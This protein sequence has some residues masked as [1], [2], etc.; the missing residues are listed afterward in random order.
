MPK[1]F[2]F[3]TR[4]DRFIKLLGDSIFSKNC[5]KTMVK[6]IPLDCCT[7]FCVQLFERTLNMHP[8]FVVSVAVSS[9]PLSGNEAS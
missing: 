1:R 2:I 3:T 7:E 4:I 6:G 8:P 5:A 9:V